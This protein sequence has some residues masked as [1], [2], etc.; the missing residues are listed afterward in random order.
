M[1]HVYYV[2][3]VQEC[4]LEKVALPRGVCGCVY[5][6]MKFLII[7]YC[8]RN[9]VYVAPPKG[10]ANS[11]LLFIYSHAISD[12]TG[13]LVFFRDLFEFY[14]RV[15]CGDNT[16]LSPMPIMDPMRTMFPR[17]IPTLDSLMISALMP[18]VRS[19]LWQ[20]PRLPW[21]Q[22]APSH[23]RYSRFFFASG[24]D[25]GLVQ[26]LA[27]CKKRKLTVGTFLNTAAMWVLGR[28]YQL[29]KPNK[30][31]KEV[32]ILPIVKIVIWGTCSGYTLMHS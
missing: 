13:A 25:A 5:F 2:I 20:A 12:G 28:Q 9:S 32:L 24:T 14:A 17:G 15:S 4:V 16:E 6:V 10:E 27:V 3:C 8:P 7:F 21:K 30:P 22:N 31:V 1:L 11:E 29:L 26:L 18:L 23:T 19:E